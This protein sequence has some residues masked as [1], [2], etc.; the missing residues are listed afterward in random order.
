MKLHGTWIIAMALA[1]SG[2]SVQPQSLAGDKKEQPKQERAKDTVVNDELTNA[3]L[4]DKVR[5]GSFCKTFT[6]KMTEGRKYQIDM[7]SG[8]F[9]S[10]LR[11]ENPKGEQVASDDD[12]GGF[13]NARIQYE[14]PTTGD[15]TISATTFGGGSTGK[16]TVTV[17]DIT[18]GELKK[19]GAAKAIELK[20]DKGAAK[21]D[22]SL[23][24][25]DTKFQNEKIAKIYVIKL[26][27]GKTYQIDHISQAFDAYLYLEGPNG[28]ILAQDDDGGD[29][30]NS[31]IVH[32]AAATG[33]YRI[34]A[35]SLGGNRTGNYSLSIQSTDGN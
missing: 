13:P 1:I 31:R 26:E 15:F 27:E 25:T 22:G 5:T 19:K 16:F 29:G 14:A 33:N 6:Y 11:L 8:A 17:K 35:T 7:V 32:K 4:K 21:H 10:Y 2:W 9:D 23:E 3:D 34:I 24:Q 12:G 30:L 20:L 18:V 28:N